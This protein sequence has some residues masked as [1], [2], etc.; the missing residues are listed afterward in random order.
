MRKH[1]LAD[2]ALVVFSILLP[3]ILVAPCSAEITIT[4]KEKWTNVFAGEKITRHFMIQST[5]QFNGRVLWTFAATN[6]RIFP[7]GRGERIL[8]IPAGQ[9]IEV[10]VPLEMP[11]LK[12]GV[13]LP[14][15]FELSVVKQGQGK[16]ETTR[17]SKWRIFFADPFTDRTKWLKD[18]QITVY[19]P[20]RD[21]NT[22]KLLEKFKIPHEEIRNPAALNEVKEGLILIGENVSFFDERGLDEILT[23]L[24]KRGLP[25]ICLAPKEGQFVLPDTEANPTPPNKLSWRKQDI[26]SELDKRLDAEAWANTPEVT[27]TSLRIKVDDGR[28]IAE[29]SNKSNG[30]SWFEV[31]YPNHGKVLV[32]GFPIVGQWENSP[33][34]RYLLAHLLEYVT[35][36]SKPN[37]ERKKGS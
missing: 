8:K 17:K 19:D 13:V 12:A 31:D 25:V 35:N 36:A 26:I 28:A 16:P 20:T 33:T 23:G 21:V 27:A 7:R 24:A 15:E 32:L 11:S 34:P 4:P 3:I 37:T 18:L 29:V 30:W 14:T 1:T 10:K 22:V 5:E 6:G 9:A 2:F